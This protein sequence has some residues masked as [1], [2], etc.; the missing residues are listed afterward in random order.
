MLQA[1][2]L[3]RNALTSNG[4]GESNER[5]W[6]MEA[7]RGRICQCSTIEKIEVNRFLNRC[8]FAH[9]ALGQL[10][11][12]SNP[13]WIAGIVRTGGARHAAPHQKF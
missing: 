12:Q 13:R 8:G 1:E 10:G 2:Q 4:S 3:A 6:D 11:C 7:I 5:D 9:D